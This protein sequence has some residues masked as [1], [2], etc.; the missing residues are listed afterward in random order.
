MLVVA[1]IRYPQISH[2]PSP[3]ASLHLPPKFISI[4]DR[5]S[6][7]LSPKRPWL[8][9]EGVGSNCVLIPSCTILYFEGGIVVSVIPLLTISFSCVGFSPIPAVSLLSLELRVKIRRCH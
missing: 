5:L 8:V 2:F 9:P 6:K 7:S 4:F 1:N 3:I